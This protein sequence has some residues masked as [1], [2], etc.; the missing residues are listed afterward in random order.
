MEINR[1]NECMCKIY[2]L[3]DI[4]LYYCYILLKNIT[5]NYTVNKRVQTPL[6]IVLSQNY[7]FK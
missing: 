4:T 1:R 7:V 2:T 5:H 6:I 3:S